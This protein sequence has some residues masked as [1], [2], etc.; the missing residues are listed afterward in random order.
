MIKTVFFDLICTQFE[1]RVRDLDLDLDLSLKNKIKK[2]DSYTHPPV[3]D[4]ALTG[5][6]KNF[7]NK[8]IEIISKKKIKIS[9]KSDIQKKFFL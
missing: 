3:L 6:H 5:N 9:A 8:K 2:G 1:N 4:A 7:Q